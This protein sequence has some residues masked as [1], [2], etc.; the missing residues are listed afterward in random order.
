MSVTPH[1]S[2]KDLE[3]SGEISVPASSDDK[4]FDDLGLEVLTMTAGRPH[5]VDSDDYPDGG[6]EAWMV[7]L[8]VSS[9][10]RPVC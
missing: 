6:F 10:L 8:G 2:Q 4:E 1:S 5:A 9:P 3:T 7:V